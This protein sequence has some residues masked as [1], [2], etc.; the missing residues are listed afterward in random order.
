LAFDLNPNLADYSG[1]RFHLAL[2]MTNGDLLVRVKLLLQQYACTIPANKARSG[3]DR[4]PVAPAVNAC[5]LDR[6][7]ERNPVTAT[8]FHWLL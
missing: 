1:R 3:K 8:R 7:A 4:K 2:D 5:D 6:Y